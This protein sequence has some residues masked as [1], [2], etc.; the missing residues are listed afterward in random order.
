MISACTEF[1]C[2]WMERQ[3]IVV[4]YAESP[5]LSCA[6]GRGLAQRGRR[7][8]IILRRGIRRGD[9]CTRSSTVGTIVVMGDFGTVNYPPF[10]A[11]RAALHEPRIAVVN[12][13]ICGNRMLTGSAERG[14]T[15]LVRLSCD[16]LLVTGAQSVLVG[17]LPT[18]VR[19]SRP[20]SR[21]K[22]RPRRRRPSW[23]VP[24]S[25]GPRSWSS[26]LGRWHQSARGFTRATRLQDRDHLIP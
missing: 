24:A 15:G 16:V 21:R 3:P 5:S 2:I 8:R 4:A 19:T 1:R 6:D 25:I 12:A 17:Q 23:P 26:R 9:R 11:G 7:V 20:A 22:W 14:D 13:G 18:D 10:L